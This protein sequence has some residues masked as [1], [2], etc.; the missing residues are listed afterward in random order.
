NAPENENDLPN[1]NSYNDSIAVNRAEAKPVFDVKLNETQPKML[2]NEKSQPYRM[3]PPASPFSIA[4]YTY[5]TAIDIER[6][7][8]SANLSE[9]SIRKTILLLYEFIRVIAFINKLHCNRGML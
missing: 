2:I 6:K 8:N 7:S 3:A 5:Y 9:E 4:I 1:I